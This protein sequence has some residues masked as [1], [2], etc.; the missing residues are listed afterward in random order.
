MT[1]A[2]IK[3]TNPENQIFWQKQLTEAEYDEV[4]N[5]VEDRSV[6]GF[7]GCFFPVRTNNWNNFSKDFFFPS[8]INYAA[9]TGD[10]FQRMIE[11]VVLFFVDLITLPIRVLTC[12]P[13]II[14]NAM[15]EERPISLY[16][17]KQNNVDSKLLETDQVLVEIMKEG[18]WNSWNIHLIEIPRSLVEPRLQHSQRGFLRFINA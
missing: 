5:C 1:V 12:I 14:Y 3:V 7:K 6:D 11:H 16:L 17:K 13:R 10:V 15:Q 4:K 9:K 2:N 8:M 18:Y